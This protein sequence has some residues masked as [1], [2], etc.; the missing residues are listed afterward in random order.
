MNIQ[1][2]SVHMRYADGQVESV[3]AHFT[4]RDE[5]RTLNLNGHVPLTAE[6][7][8]GNENIS[9]LER[10]AQQYISEKLNAD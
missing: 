1:I 3:Q 9:A 4:A 6:E 5:D 7:Y 2:T 8:E 10:I